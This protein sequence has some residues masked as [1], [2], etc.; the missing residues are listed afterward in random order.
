MSPHWS[1]V[2]TMSSGSAGHDPVSA[3]SGPEVRSDDEHAPRTRASASAIAATTRVRVRG[4]ADEGI[5][6]ESESKNRNQNQQALIPCHGGRQPPGRRPSRIAS[7][8]R[9]ISQVSASA[10]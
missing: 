8:A 3:V 10:A 7:V 5:G 2:T 4:I 9:P 1:T 6:S